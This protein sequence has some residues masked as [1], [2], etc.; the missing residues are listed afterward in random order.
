MCIYII[1]NSTQISVLPN[2]QSRE[3]SYFV[4]VFI[5]SCDGE[6]LLFVISENGGKAESEESESSERGRRSHDDYSLGRGRSERSTSSLGKTAMSKSLPS[7]RNAALST[8]QSTTASPSTRRSLLHSKSTET[9]NGHSSHRPIANH[10]VPSKTS[11]KTENKTQPFVRY[12]SGRGTTNSGFVRAGS[13]RGVGIISSF[14]R[15]GSGR[16]NGVGSNFVR[17]GSE[18]SPSVNSNYNNRSSKSATSRGSTATG[19]LSSA[20]FGGGERKQP[21]PKSSKVMYNSHSSTSTSSSNG[22]DEPRTLSEQEMQQGSESDD[23]M[24]FVFDGH[25]NSQRLPID[26][27]AKTDRHLRTLNHR[28]WKC[29]KYFQSKQ[30]LWIHKK[31]LD[32]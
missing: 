31:Q 3:V 15:S 24:L 18:R 26:M 28:C 16:G 14:V 27:L 32:H 10:S 9:Q 4:I 5:S 22:P 2:L 25:G 30:E 21:T 29:R 13:G 23:E 6:G 8:V 17:S 19:R 11:F 7:R 1:L 20:S 12:G